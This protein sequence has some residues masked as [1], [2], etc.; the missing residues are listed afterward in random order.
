M[1]TLRQVT[2]HPPPPSTRV[3]RSGD[4]PRSTAVSE[5]GESILGAGRRR[6]VAVGAS[7][8]RF[9][10]AL[11]L[12][13]TSRSS[14]RRR[15]GVLSANMCWRRVSETG[16]KSGKVALSR[17]RVR[18][19]AH[20]PAPRQQKWQRP[21]PSMTPAA[22]PSSAC[23]ARLSLRRRRAVPGTAVVDHRVAD[24]VPAPGRRSGRGSAAP[25][26]PCTPP[27]RTG[28]EWPD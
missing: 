14:T 27:T 1:S 28:R 5:S 8:W 6:V 20:Q 19:E 26:R 13:P 4:E 7:A 25:W 9:R 24:A 10:L 22:V 12:G 21:P 18:A 23:V 15:N 16:A 17:R 11:P 3:F 2:P